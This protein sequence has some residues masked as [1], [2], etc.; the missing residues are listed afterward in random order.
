MSAL[1]ESSALPKMSALPESSALRNI[2]SAQVECSLTKEQN[3]RLPNVSFSVL[4]SAGPPVA[5]FYELRRIISF[6]QEIL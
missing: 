5:P 3:L 6:F 1:P 2:F 4:E